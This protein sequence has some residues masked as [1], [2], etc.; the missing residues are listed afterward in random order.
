MYRL[1][2]AVMKIISNLS[3]RNKDA[4]SSALDDIQTNALTSKEEARNDC[5]PLA[6]VEAKEIVNL[7]YVNEPFFNLILKIESVF[8][9]LL[10][11]DNIAAYGVRI[12]ND[13]VMVLGMED[14]GFDD[15][16]SQPHD[17]D[18]K[19]EVI[20]RILFS[21]GRIRG[22]DF[23]RKV[24]AKVGAKHHETLRSALGTTAA[25]AEKKA[26]EAK[27]TEEQSPRMKYL[28]KQRKKDLVSMCKNRKVNLSGTKNTLAA[29]IVEHDETTQ[30][31]N[32]S[33][34]APSLAILDDENDQHLQ[35]L[36]NDMDNETM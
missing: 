17:N 24:N 18:V 13:I 15:F 3:R 9:T 12:V 11:E 29:R 1:A 32:S 35:M 28:L 8:H 4:Y 21:Y 20:R 34:V 23:V 6:K 2:G 14:F 25:I 30:S 26:K 10:S 27:D 19:V 33:Q 5:L 36:I 16:F 31:A 7:C 22:K